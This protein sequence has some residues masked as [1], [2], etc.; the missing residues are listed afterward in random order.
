M[1]GVFAVLIGY[2]IGIIM[3]AVIFFCVEWFFKLKYCLGCPVL[4]L[5]VFIGQVSPFTGVGLSYFLWDKNQLQSHWGQPLWQ[6][7][8]VL[9]GYLVGA[10]IGGLI[11]Y[12]VCPYKGPGG[13]GEIPGNFLPYFYAYLGILIGALPVAS[14]SSYLL[15]RTTNFG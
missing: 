8:I 7:F 14:L 9:L 4:L 15:F 11:G 12:A 13:E 1:G 2:G 5:G 3:T 10:I 6:T